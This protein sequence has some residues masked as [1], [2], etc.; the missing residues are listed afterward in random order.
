MVAI[1]IYLLLCSLAAAA[2]K[3]VLAPCCKYDW[4]KRLANLPW[5]DFLE[6]A[7]EQVTASCG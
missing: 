5:I 7:H 3:V 2:K 4:G 6:G 1:C